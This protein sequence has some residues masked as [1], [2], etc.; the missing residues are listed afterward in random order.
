[1]FQESEWFWFKP[2]GRV[3]HDMGHL[4]AKKLKETYDPFKMQNLPNALAKVETSQSAIDFVGKYGFLGYRNHTNEDISLGEPVNWFLAQ[5]R[6]VRF[7]LYLLFCL[8]EQDDQKL[9][10]LLR[11]A[12]VKIRFEEVDLVDRYNLSLENI[13]YEFAEGAELVIRN[14]P[15]SSLKENQQLF[16]KEILT[17]IINTNTKGVRR[18]LYVTA[19]GKISHQLE[20]SALIEVIWHHVGDAA[21]PSG[22]G[23]RICKECGLPFIV[24]DK[25]QR[26]CPGDDFS[27]GSTCGTRYRVRKSRKK[28][29]AQDAQ[30]EKG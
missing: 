5:S 26:F 1:M 22:N 25:R 9:T 11:T 14:Y 27:S 16:A 3:W 21:L 20:A 28:G 24:T 2:E 8:Q 19:E 29:D 17:H 12:E 23:I 13:T 7:G 10:E 6:S 18:R 15:V 30:G 4:Y